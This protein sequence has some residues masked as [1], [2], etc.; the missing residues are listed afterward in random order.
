MTHQHKSSSNLS[1]LL[2]FRAH[3]KI[4]E[5][6]VVNWSLCRRRNR[7]LISTLKFH[8]FDV[9][10]I[11]IALPQQYSVLNCHDS[12]T[13]THT[14]QIRQTNKISAG[15]NLFPSIVF[16][17]GFWI[18]LEWFTACAEC[19][20]VHSSFISHWFSSKLIT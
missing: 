13:H 1:A 8:C 3:G 15:S 19:V 7:C 17:M 6:S 9:K 4:Y 18:F 20:F 2:R 10:T 14:N 16:V 5:K 12:R 11:I